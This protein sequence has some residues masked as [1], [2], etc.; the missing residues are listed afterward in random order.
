[1]TNENIILWNKLAF[2]TRS[3][4]KNYDL[5]TTNENIITEY[6]GSVSEL[7]IKERLLPLLIGEYAFS[8]WNLKLGRMLEVDLR[9]LLKDYADEDT[10]IELQNVI[11]N[12]KFSFDDYDKVVLIHNFVLR[13]D[14]RKKEIT[15]EFVETMYRDFYGDRVAMIVLTKPIQNNVVDNDYYLNH[16]RAMEVFKEINDEGDLEKTKTPAYLYY[17]LKDLH[18]KDDIEY[19]EYKLFAVADR[20]GFTRIAESRLF[21]FNPDKTVVR[22]LI[23]M[24]KI[25]QLKH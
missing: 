7:R 20:C 18:D 22:L 14:Y 3:Y 5:I 21:Q 19:N 23:K 15:E 24:K 11:A 9:K 10:Y 17:S 25:K 16:H 2:K 6:E 4:R 12:N 13:A 1:M 8:V